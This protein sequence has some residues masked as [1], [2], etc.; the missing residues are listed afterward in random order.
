MVLERYHG[1]GNDYLVLAK[2]HALTPE[3]VQEVCHR[4]T[5]VGGDG[6]LEPI[7]PEGHADFGVRIW[8]PDGSIA[9]K[10]GN[11][12]RIFCAWLVSQG[13]PAEHTVWTGTD[14]V[15]AVVDDQVTIEMG[16]AQF[17]PAKVP[18]TGAEPVFAEPMAIDG[19]T[20]PIYA[21]GMGNPHAISFFEGDL[22]ALPWRRWGAA[23]EVHERFPNRTNC[24]FARVIDRNTLEI[25]IWERGAGETMASGSSS[26]AAATAGVWT[27]RL[28][29]G[30]IRVLMPGGELQVLVRD[31][32][33]IRLRGPVEHICSVQVAPEWLT[34]R[35][36]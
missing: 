3:L 1:L 11:G 10:S 19:D 4:H 27:G 35:L 32:Y 21:V 22:D 5:G 26:C 25:R 24:Q 9:E 31:D 12:L 8:N 16:T 36:G 29:H 18:V 30:M 6:I 28:D 7:D 33:A 17:E 20:L 14:T 34:R 13:A 2:P 15:R 23:L